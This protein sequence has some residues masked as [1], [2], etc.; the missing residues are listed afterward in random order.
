M[1]IIEDIMLALERIPIWKRVAA[2]PKEVE[3]LRARVT[4]L[5]A[6]LSGKTGALCPMCGSVNFKIVSSGPDSTF[7]ALGMQRDLYRC[8]DCQH[9]ESRQRRTRT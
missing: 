9:S 7:G 4:A 2:M 8:Q 6:K 3:D 1:G 5:E